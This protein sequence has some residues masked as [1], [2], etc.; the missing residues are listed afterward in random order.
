MSGPNLPSQA[1]VTFRFTGADLAMGRAQCQFGCSHPEGVTVEEMIDLHEDFGVALNATTAFGI[2][3][4]EILYKRGPMATGPTTSRFVSHNGDVTGL[5]APSQVAFILQ[6]KPFDTSGRF[7]GR[8]YWPGVPAAAVDGAGLLTEGYVN[9]INA[10][11]G[12]YFEAL[13]DVG[14]V[15]LI[16]SSKSSDFTQVSSFA[17]DPRVGTQRRRLR[18]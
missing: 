10:V 7:G 3:L 13:A 4:S 16:Y 2:Y 12:D 15:P 17:I 6:K 5:V 14:S 18:R 1:L 8:A 11:L 9:Q